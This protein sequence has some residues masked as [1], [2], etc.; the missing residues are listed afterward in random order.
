MT[1]QSQNPAARRL[2]IQRQLILEGAVSV[3]ALSRRLG[4]SLPTVRRDLAR[5]EE[6]GLVRRTHGGA[7]VEAPRGADQAF[8]LREQIDTAEKRAIARAAIRLLEPDATVLMNDGSTVLAVA[9]EIVAT[10]LKLTVVTPGV[11]IAT[12]LSA[13]PRVTSYLLG[14]NLRHQSLG[15]TGAFAEQMLRS[16]HGDL[17]L[18]AAE[19]FTAKDG[20]TYS[21]EVDASLARLMHEQASRTVVLATSRKLQERDRILALPATQVHLLITG[22]ED[23]QVIGEFR[24]LGI[25]V[26]VASEAEEDGV[27]Y[28]GPRTSQP[29][30]SDSRDTS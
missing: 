21:Y 2:F 16:I 22:C 3:E 10:N 12:L 19:G 29:S 27:G 24:Q 1:A 15:T 6:G 14:G 25:E 18:V 30:E 23:E 7:T 11:N 20:L 13:S 5:L 4:V 9:R 17:A 8:A 26:I 28:G